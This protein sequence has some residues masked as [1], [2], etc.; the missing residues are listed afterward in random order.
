M[1]T[2]GKVRVNK[3]RLKGI[4]DIYDR[5][6]EEEKKKPCVRVTIFLF[7]PAKLMYQN[8]ANGVVGGGLGWN[9]LLKS[10]HMYADFSA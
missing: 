6:L 4:F 9:D 10:Q 2:T 3:V 1:P 8:K 5:K 7:G